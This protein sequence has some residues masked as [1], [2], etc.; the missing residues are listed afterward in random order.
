MTK[1]LLINC[2][3][4]SH[5]L[6][7]SIRVWIKLAR[8][9][10]KSIQLTMKLSGCFSCSVQLSRKP[11]LSLNLWQ[12]PE[13]V[14]KAWIKHIVVA[15]TTIKHEV[16]AKAYIFYS[17]RLWKKIIRPEG[18]AKKNNLAPILPEKNFFR[19]RHRSQPPPPR[20]PRISNGPCLN[21]RNFLSND[22]I[23]LNQI[24]TLPTMVKVA[25]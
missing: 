9:P 14:V 19:P 11:K 25:V 10:K 3:W 5:R 15:K 13:F 1:Q 12:K 17:F 4:C 18:P 24:C 20:P 23:D 8:E 21:Y 7:R 16:A 2:E 22:L 6:I